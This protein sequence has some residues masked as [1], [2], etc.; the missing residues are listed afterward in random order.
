MRIEEK[1][2]SSLIYDEEY[3]RKVTPF[4]KSEYFQ[5]RTEKLLSQEILEFFSKYNKPPT[6]EVLSIT[7]NQKENLSADDVKSLNILIENCTNEPI[8]QEWLIESTEIFCKDRAVYNAIMQSIKIIDG[9]D[10]NLKED[11][12]PSI[13]SEAL[14][15]SF[16]KNVGHDYLDDSDSRFEF[17]HK[18]EDKIAFDLELM[19]KITAG[20]LSRKSLNVILAS[21]GAGKTM[22]MCHMAA[23]TL[24]QGRNVLYITMEMAEERI[25][26]RVDANLMNLDINELKVIDKKTFDTRL[27]KV[28][29]KTRG[30][31]I[32]KEYPTAGAHAGN[33]R[34][35]LE[36]LKIKKDFTPDLLIVDYLN[37]C[38]SSRM[39]M[40]GSVNSYTYIKSIAEELRGLAVEYNI[41]IV[42]ATQVNR[43][44]ATSSDMELTDT[45]ESWGLPAT[46]D[47]MFA[48]IRTE[49]LD[50]LNQVL[51]KQL[52]NRYNDP[53]YYKKF[54]LGVDRPKMKFY[55]TEQSAQKDLVDSGQDDKPVFD[56]SK[57]G[58]SMKSGGGGFN[59]FKF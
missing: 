5:N 38:A 39:R 57:F 12:I 52:K 30:K 50:E 26:E 42:T 47:L 25:A 10:K 22:F 16:D 14:A 9:Q 3:C 7:F 29:M 43:S 19:N 46:A 32:I 51:I 37:I 34:A 21:T 17:Y 48:L 44:G 33:F 23:S 15:V 35:L 4:I 8:N 40:S 20:G 24:M 53:S 54:V 56:K 1:I 28:T 49:E 11:A 36:E 59:S 55:D 27:N 18:K 45:S 41:P 2:L 13:L 31:F 58:E 6:K